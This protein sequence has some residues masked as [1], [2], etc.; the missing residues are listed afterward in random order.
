MNKYLKE[1][2]HRGLMFSGFGPIIISI[3][4]LCLSLSLDDFTLSGYETFLAI[5]STYVLAFVLAGASVFNQI[6]HWSVLKSTFFHFMTYY[7]SYII[8]Y[9]VNSWIPFDFKFV[10]IFTA[11]FVLGYFVIWLIV[12]CT[13]K[14]ISKKLNKKLN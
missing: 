11:I 7:I 10:L 12:S 9:L 8:C 6:E 1:F 13:I 14:Q 3:V 2:L 5:I 4:Y